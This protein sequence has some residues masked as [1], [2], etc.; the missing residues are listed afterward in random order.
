MAM[1]MRG[2]VSDADA[3]SVAF[4]AEAA[5]ASTMAIV[6]G[7]R[8]VI[9]PCAGTADSLPSAAGASETALSSSAFSSTL[10][11]II[12]I[13]SLPLPGTCVAFILALA[14]ILSLTLA[15]A[16]LNCAMEA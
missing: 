11:P 4:A 15:L 14:L 6:G 12:L 8:V 3:A 10:F 2:A 13:D 1:P 16:V 5:D 7:A 9:C